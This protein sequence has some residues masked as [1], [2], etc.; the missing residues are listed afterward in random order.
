MY[1]KTTSDSPNLM[2]TEIYEENI[3][4]IIHDEIILD[5]ITPMIPLTDK[6]ILQLQQCQRS[7]VVV[8]PD[9]AGDI[10]SLPADT[11]RPN[12]AKALSDSCTLSANG[13]Q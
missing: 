11:V 13:I 7:Q 9:N 3:E 8:C 5:K 12:V 4:Y 2:K 6:S 1:P 10:L